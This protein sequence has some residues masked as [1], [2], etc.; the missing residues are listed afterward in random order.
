AETLDE[1]EDGAVAPASE[2]EVYIHDE[3]LQTAVQDVVEKVVYAKEL[4]RNTILPKCRALYPE[5]EK[6]IDSII[7]APKL[8]PTVSLSYYPEFYNSEEYQA[9]V[10]DYDLNGLISINN[11]FTPTE[12]LAFITGDKLRTLLYTGNENLDRFVQQATEG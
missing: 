1:T 2:R 11:D 6:R 12:K 7:L 5:L 9:L 3:V 4:A 10:S 8:I